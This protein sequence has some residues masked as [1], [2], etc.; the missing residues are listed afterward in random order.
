MKLLVAT[1]NT[2]KLREISRMLPDWEILSKNSDAEET[3]STFSGNALLKARAVSVLNK[4]VWVLADDSGL[5]VEAL[6]FEPGVRSARY[7]GAD[8]DT[9]ANNALLLKNMAGITNRKARFV[10]AMVLISPDG[11]EFHFEGVCD[12]WIIEK[13]VGEEGFGYDPLFVPEGFDKTFA[14][15]PLDVKNTISHRAKALRKAKEFLSKAY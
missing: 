12:G 15:L 1:H 10:C 6:G 11:E 8:G 5:E 13:P 9:P 3:E 4:G 2:G 7:A 14:S